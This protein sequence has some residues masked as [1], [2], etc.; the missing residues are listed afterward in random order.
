MGASSFPFNSDP[1]FH[2]SRPLH[3]VPTDA[4]HLR[5][6]R[7]TRQHPCGHRCSLFH[8]RPIPAD[9]TLPETP[10]P[11][12]RYPTD[13]RPPHLGPIPLTP[14]RHPVGPRR[15]S[16]LWVT[17]F[18]NSLT[19][20]PH[21]KPIVAPVPLSSSRFPFHRTVHPSLPVHTASTPSL[22]KRPTPYLTNTWPLASSN[23]RP[24][25]T[26]ARW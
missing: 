26:P 10:E 7:S 2:P 17:S 13:K 25:R 6:P 1:T 16:T 4:P 15:S 11:L 23:C 24:P 9:D 18:A 8:P 3:R 14:M 5:R 12:K 21:P 22:L 20:S 19:S